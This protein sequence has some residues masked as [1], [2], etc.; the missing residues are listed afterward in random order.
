[1]C[2]NSSFSIDANVWTWYNQCR[3]VESLLFFNLHWFQLLGQYTVSQYVICITQLIRL[4]H[5]K[6]FEI[7]VVQEF[8]ACGLGQCHSCK[9]TFQKRENFALWKRTLAFDFT[10]D[11]SVICDGEIG[12]APQCQENGVEF[13][14][15]CLAVPITEVSTLVWNDLIIVGWVFDEYDWTKQNLCKLSHTKT[16]SHANLV[17]SKRCYFDYTPFSS[18]LNDRNLCRSKRLLSWASLHSHTTP[19]VQQQLYTL[20]TRDCRLCFLSWMESS[21]CKQQHRACRSKYW[22]VWYQSQCSA[23][24]VSNGQPR[25]Q[26]RWWSHRV[27]GPIFPTKTN[28]IHFT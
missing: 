4:V 8:L 1:M 6:G 24:T 12:L 17:F 23:S 2:D 18:K 22:T 9:N 7:V 14:R 20:H 11:S 28:T 25:S 26:I 27:I 16:M 13:T 10:Y 19:Y 21:V 3:F 5:D 15:L